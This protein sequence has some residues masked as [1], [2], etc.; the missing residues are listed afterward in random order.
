MNP[1]GQFAHSLASQL[2]K[3]GHHITSFGSRKNSG[4]HRHIS[5]P[6]ESKLEQHDRTLDHSSIKYASQRALTALAIRA[7]NEGSVDILHS[8]HST[9]MDLSLTA[10]K[11][12]VSTVHFGLSDEAVTKLPLLFL[13][14]NGFP[15]VT[16]VCIS[17]HQASRFEKT[18]PLKTQHVIPSGIDVGSFGFSAEKENHLLWLGR[19][20][21]E[22]QPH[23]AI[24]VALQAQVPLI[25]AGPNSS[26]EQ[27]DSEYFDRCIRPHL[28][29]EKIKYINTIDYSQRNNLLS[30]SRA[31]LF[32]S[33]SSDALGMTIMESLASG[34]P[35]YALNGNAAS[36][37]ILDTHTGYVGHSTADLAREIVKDQ[38]TDYLEI[39]RYAETAFSIKKCAQ[40]YEELY[41]SLLNI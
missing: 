15:N 16:F 5:L 22:K 39:R 19:I 35:V 4:F 23:L 1:E 2:V 20:S 34:T 30:R 38:Y 26:T 37:L 36:E 11:P 33:S 27:A 24:E 31:T 18:L 32:T 3:M 7:L 17:S 29:N 40:R 6:Y 28:A 21:P 41:S 9:L 10:Q 8:H 13:A 12:I 25:L 14:Y